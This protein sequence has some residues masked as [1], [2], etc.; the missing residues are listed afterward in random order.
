ML[1]WSVFYEGVN[2]C[3]L[4]LFEAERFF[5]PKLKKQENRKLPARWLITLAD[6]ASSLSGYCEQILNAIDYRSR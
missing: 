3:S 6:I 5:I 4:T 2:N 1:E